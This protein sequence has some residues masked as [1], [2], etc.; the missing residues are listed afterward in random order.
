MP[1]IK[2]LSSLA[3][4]DWVVPILYGNADLQEIHSASHAKS[5]LLSLNEFPAHSPSMWH[6]WVRLS[7]AD[8]VSKGIDF[9]D[10]PV[11]KC[12]NHLL[13]RVNDVPRARNYRI[14]LR[15]L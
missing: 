9:R 14:I 10:D 15:F 12:E 3:T 2:L 7:G 11:D 4:A 8:E 5:L 13:L 1:R 6:T